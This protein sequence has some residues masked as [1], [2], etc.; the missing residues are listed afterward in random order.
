MKEEETRCKLS[1]VICM[2]IICAHLNTIEDILDT[3][4]ECYSDCL[5]QSNLDDLQD[6]RVSLY[7]LRDDIDF[8]VVYDKEEIVNE[9]SEE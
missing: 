4:N 5:V 9:A 6:M 3:I 7:K 1:K 2:E 8:T